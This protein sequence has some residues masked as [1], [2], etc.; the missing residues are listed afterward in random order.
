MLK[1]VRRFFGS[2][3]GPTAVE[4]SVLLALILLTCVSGARTLGCSVNDSMTKAAEKLGN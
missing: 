2:D 3:D 1:S 4:Y